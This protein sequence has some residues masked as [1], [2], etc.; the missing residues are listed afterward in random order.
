MDG[1]MKELTL[2]FYFQQKRGEFFSLFLANT[3]GG[4]ANPAKPYSNLFP[5]PVGHPAWGSTPVG[6]YPNPMRGKSNRS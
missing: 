3:R 1:Q 6:P 2:T 5:N 4:G